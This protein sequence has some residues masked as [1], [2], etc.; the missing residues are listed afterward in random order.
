MASAPQQSQAGKTLTSTGPIIIV[1]LVLAAA[2][3]VAHQLEPWENVQALGTYGPLFAATLAVGSLTAWA[4][5]RYRSFRQSC[6]AVIVMSAIFLLEVNASAPRFDT[7]SVKKLAATLRPLLKPDDAVATYSTYY[8]DLPV[9]LERRIIIVD[10]KGELEFGTTME[11]TS[12][13]MMNPEAFWKLWRGKETVYMVT[14]REIFQTIR[15]DP[16][17]K[18]F[19]V[20]EDQDNIVLCNREANR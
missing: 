9:Y 14:T 11:D 15:R 5:A 13:W 2:F 16:N 1:I 3:L 17:L 19:P 6:I 20:E 8:Q 10:W 12:S 18:L 4:L 7:R